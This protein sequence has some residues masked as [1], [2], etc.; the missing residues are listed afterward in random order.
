MYSDGLCEQKPIKNLGENG[1]WAYTGTA[2]IFWVPPI[3]SGTDKTAKF[4]F[5]R[6]IHRVHANKIPSK[7]LGENGAW[8]N[9]GTPQ[10][11][12]V[13][14]IIS[15][16]GKATNVKFVRYIQRVH[17]NKSR[18]KI[19]EKMARG[20]IQELPKVF[21]KYPLL[22]QEGIKLR[23]LNLPGI[24]TGPSEQKPFKIL[25]ENGA[26]AH[27]GTAQIFWIPPI[28]SGMGKATNFKFCTH[29]LSIDRNKSPL[30]ISGKVAGCVMRTLES[31]PC[32]HSG[33]WDVRNHLS[34][35]RNCMSQIFVRFEFY[36]NIMLS[37][38]F[39]LLL[40]TMR[41]DLREGSYRICS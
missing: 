4:K 12:E 18:L 11:F 5:G 30:Q 13:P 10:I 7:I 36:Y 35:Q 2:Q 9:Q 6:Y 26:W 19:W 28:I 37:T 39:N 33:R 41:F 23:T 14:P 31:F 1:A 22:S 27:S 8:A 25:E 40:Q 3:I 15:I 20:R 38:L 34:T 24:F 21:F 32:T 16:R 29:I 17:A